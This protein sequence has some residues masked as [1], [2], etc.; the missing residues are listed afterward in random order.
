MLFRSFAHFI[1][2]IENPGFSLA[3]E[4][5]GAMQSRRR[6]QFSVSDVVSGI[7][8][9]V[10]LAYARYFRSTLY[11]P[12]NTKIHLQLDIEQIPVRENRIS[13]GPEKDKYGRQIPDISWSISDADLIN[14]K[15]TADQLLNKWPG[16]AGGLPELIP[17]NFDCNVIK[18]HDAY[19]PEIG[20][21]SCRERV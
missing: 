14:I 11:I 17:A 7:G 9:L 16:A 10:A 4:V 12:P 1:F 2:D 15:A 6:P 21:A 13:L 20:R 19:H 5:L 18:P 3:K 8:G